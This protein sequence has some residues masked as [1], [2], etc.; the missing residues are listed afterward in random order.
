MVP[1]V[2]DGKSRWERRGA[3]Q[4]VQWRGA[5]ELRDFFAR[6]HALHQRI[7]HDAA[8][9]GG[10]SE[11]GAAGQGRWWTPKNHAVYAIRDGGPLFGAGL[12]AGRFVSTPGVVPH[13]AAGHY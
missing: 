4:F 2:V 9:D 7:D 13:D 6:D 10:H 1:D 12:P 5:R 3:V 11:A 8:A